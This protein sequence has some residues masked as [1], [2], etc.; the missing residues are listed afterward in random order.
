MIDP[1]WSLCTKAL[2]AYRKNNNINAMYFLNNAE[3]S[4]N[5]LN[6]LN[7]VLFE[8]RK[9]HLYK[10]KSYLEKKENQCKLTPPNISY[11]N[12]DNF[13]VVLF[14]HTRLDTLKLILDSLS[15]QGALKYTEV[16][17]DGHQ[18]NHS[19]KLKV[20][21][22]Y[23]L[24]K[25]YPVKEIHSQAGAFGFRKMLLLGLIQMSDRYKDIL[26]LEDD[27]F[28]TRDAVSIFRKEL[29]NIRED[30]G[31]FS[32]YGHPFLVEGE[33]DICARFQGWGWATTSE[34]LIPVLHQLIE[35]YSMTE[36]KY[37]EFVSQ[38]FT[39][40]V[41]ERIEITPL[42]LPSHTFTKF[43][44]WDETLCLLTALNNQVHKKTPIRTIYN[45]GMG[46]DSTHFSENKM[47]REPPFNMVSP[48]EAWGFF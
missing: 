7:P 36:K 16:F 40:Q 13:G 32:V 21:K 44:A 18:G 23:D 39:N 25:K 12:K 26:V 31:I 45:C 29:D 48:K 30:K 3:L 2:N 5:K 6:K 9:L 47:F 28:P 10:L 14:G 20:G 24:V 46:N 11:N 38:V 15:K 42:R 17:L 37:L 19:N 41:R 35:C 33:T 43:F 22:T 27:C 34:K 4:L 8:K 1:F